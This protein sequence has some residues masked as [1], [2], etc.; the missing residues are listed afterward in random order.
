MNEAKGIFVIG[1][2]IFFTGIY[3]CAYA[4][5]AYLDWKDRKKW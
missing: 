1:I 3:F 4:Y 2:L 5:A